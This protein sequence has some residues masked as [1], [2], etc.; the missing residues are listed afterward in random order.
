MEEIKKIENRKTGL[1][2][3]LIVLGASLLVFAM[4]GALDTNP[5]TLLLLV[6]VILFHESGHWVGMRLYGYRDVKMFFIPFFL[7]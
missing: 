3:A 2:Q 4:I 5:M 6:A 1:V 7:V